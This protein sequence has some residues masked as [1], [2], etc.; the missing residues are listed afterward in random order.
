MTVRRPRLPL[1]ARAVLAP[2]VALTLA[3][4]GL[5]ATPRPALFLTAGLL[6]VVLGFGLGRR[7]RAPT[8]RAG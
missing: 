5:A 3:T 1:V 6:V 7:G 8:N 4:A 2:V